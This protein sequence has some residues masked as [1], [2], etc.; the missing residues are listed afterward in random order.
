MGTF[1]SGAETASAVQ[2]QPLFLE[3]HDPVA[4]LTLAAAQV[5]E[6]EGDGVGLAHKVVKLVLNDLERSNV[7]GPLT[8][9]LGQVALLRFQAVGD[10]HQPAE[11]IGDLLVDLG[12]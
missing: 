6:P 9:N 1:V 5:L 7:V 12:R 10:V 11:E 2:L 8:G 4:E 3:A